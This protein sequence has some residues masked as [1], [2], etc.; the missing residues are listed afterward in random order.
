MT[1]LDI[2][3]LHER[4]VQDVCNECVTLIENVSEL[5]CECKENESVESLNRVCDNFENEI[6]NDFDVLQRELLKE[7]KYVSFREIGNYLKALMI[8][9]TVDNLNRVEL[10]SDA[11]I[12][13][14][15]CA[16]VYADPC[17]DGIGTFTS[18]I[19][20][21]GNYNGVINYGKGL[22][23]ATEWDNLNN[24]LM[25]KITDHYVEYLSANFAST[26]ETLTK[27]DFYDKIWE[28][29]D[30]GC[31]KFDDLVNAYKDDAACVSMKKLLQDKIE[32]D[33]EAHT[34]TY[35]TK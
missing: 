26:E 28:C 29:I 14:F 2:F 30:D 19:V 20:C 24:L 13:D 27:D 31:L 7:N 4:D 15:G 16:G 10:F 33:K 6:M 25:E 11:D 18:S 9:E 12:N 21:T 1:I 17:K 22:Y 8:Y 34:N 32:A 5:L 3:G 35:W 23:S